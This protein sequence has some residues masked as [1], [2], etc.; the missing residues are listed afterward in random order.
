MRHRSAERLRR[1]AR[2]EGE[3]RSRAFADRAGWEAALQRDIAVQDAVRLLGLVPANGP[4]S[5][6]DARGSVFRYRIA[7]Y[8]PADFSVAAGVLR[9]G[10]WDRLL[11]VSM[12][13]ELEPLTIDE[14]T[15]EAAR[16]AR[17]VRQL[18]AGGRRR[19]ERG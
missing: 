17:C 15:R 7:G 10:R 18:R 11:L 13:A 12:S 4:E 3:G 8:S 19:W 16:S 1:L 5:G 14:V 2:E 6:Y 9:S